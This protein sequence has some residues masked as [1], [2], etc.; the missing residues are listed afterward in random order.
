MTRRSGRTAYQAEWGRASVMSKIKY[1]I[2]LLELAVILEQKNNEIMLKSY[3]IERLKKKLA[4][5]EKM[6]DNAP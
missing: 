2:L 5:A 3:E 4:E 6:A 1:D